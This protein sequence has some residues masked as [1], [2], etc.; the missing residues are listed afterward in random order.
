MNA[1]QFIDID[2]QYDFDGVTYSCSCSLFTTGLPQAVCT[3]RLTQPGNNF[4]T[5]SS[6]G[7]YPV[8]T[9][10]VDDAGHLVSPTA[11]A[12]PLA[13]LVVIYDTFN[14]TDQ[15]AGLGQVTSTQPGPITTD[16]PVSSILSI[17]VIYN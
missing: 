1:S 6:S 12:S 9:L 3:T 2:P 10:L 7:T 14:S 8:T 17:I 5:Y 13:Q 11:Y 4:Q 15:F 16:D